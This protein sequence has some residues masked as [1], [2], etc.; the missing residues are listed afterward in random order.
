LL[1]SA[2]KLHLFYADGMLKTLIRIFKTPRVKK[3]RRVIL[4][5]KGQYYNL[6]EIYTKINQTYFEG[7][8]NLHITW[9]NP[10]K[11]RYQRRIVLGCYHRDKKLVKINRVLDQPDIP[12]Y[13]ISFV[14]YHE[15]LHHVAP[16]IEQRF[17]KRQIHHQE[18]K[19][20]EKKFQEYV[21]VKE[22]RKQSKM[23]WFVD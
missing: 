2:K 10:K 1:K 15:M 17:R 21:L 5:K 4:R 7:K 3:P 6:D 12:E 19:D 18:F 9:F 20:L 23:R 11:S 13:Y 14:V 22:F 8:L 16:P